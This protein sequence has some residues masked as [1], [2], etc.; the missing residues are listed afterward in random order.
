M[1]KALDPHAREQ[2]SKPLSGSKVNPT[3]HSSEVDQMNT[4]KTY[5]CDRTF[6]L[7]VKAL[8]PHARGARFKT[9]EWLQGQPNLSF[10][11]GRSNEYREN[12]WLRQSLDTAMM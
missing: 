3:F 1:V 11:R 12:L 7:V 10:I 4:E 8:D 9:T 2:G 5:G 6:G